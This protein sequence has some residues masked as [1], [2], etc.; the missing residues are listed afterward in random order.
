[1]GRRSS[2]AGQGTGAAPGFETVG[3]TILPG[4]PLPE[5]MSD[6]PEEP[7]LGDPTPPEADHL[8]S[9]GAMTSSADPGSTTGSAAGAMDAPASPAAGYHTGDVPSAVP[10]PRQPALVGAIP[11]A[12]T[13]AAAAA[14]APSP[15]AS[16]P[17]SPGP[18]GAGSV[19]PGAGSTYAPPGPNAGVGSPYAPAAP[20]GSQVGGVGSPYAPAAA[21]GVASPYAPAAPAGYAGQPPAHPAAAQP[22]T[23][24]GPGQPGGQAP[25][26]PGA[27]L[28]SQ[29]AGSGTATMP[30]P[31]PPTA[32]PGSAGPSTVDAGP[33]NRAAGAA[34]SNGHAPSHTNPDGPPPAPSAGWISPDRPELSPE[35]VALLTWWAEMIAKG[36]F[37]APN[38]APGA[39]GGPGSEDPDAEPGHK[40]SS[41]TRSAGR[42]GADSGRRRSAKVVALSLAVVAIGAL[43][44]VFGQRALSAAAADPAAVPT[45]ELTMPA[46]VGEL[47]SVSGPEVG[48]QLVPMVG[49]GLRPAGVTVTAAY[50]TDPAAPVVLAA[51]ATTVAANDSAADQLIA[52]AE[53]AGATISEPVTG[54]GATEGVTCAEVTENPAGPTGS[55]CVWSATGMRG[56]TYMV[57]AATDA[58][59]QMAADLR[60][61]M[62]A[63]AAG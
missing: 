7:T 22:S 42:A 33:A 45:T 28:G 12:M 41:A 40:R 20:V 5:W 19:P 48:A 53:R 32:G 46:T 52:W 51:M 44:L 26:G 49:F 27:H 1:M 29:S 62:P 2:K 17:F 31:V 18:L 34:P 11:A 59:L 10:D 54:S 14:P 37:P 39:V 55:V 13:M 23:H 56:Q 6:S 63:P 25:Y 3:V 50:A 58:G 60:A 24:T 61:A 35:H 30:A 9:A 4:H 47:V 43:A 57:G 38:G 16:G 36:Q 21:S 8:D 15:Y